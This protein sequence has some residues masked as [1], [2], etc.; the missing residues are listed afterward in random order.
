[1]KILHL[2]DLHFCSKHLKWVNCAMSAAVQI[3]ADEKIDAWIISGD[4]FDATMPVHEPTVDRYAQHLRLLADISPGLVLY[5]TASHD[6]PGSLDF[7]RTIGGRYP[8]ELVSS[9][10]Q[11]VLEYLEDDV[12]IYRPQAW[13]NVEKLPVHIS[14]N[15]RL[16][17]SA[18]PSLNKALPEVMSKGPREW[19]Q[20]YMTSWAQGNAQARNQRIPTLLV[21]HGTVTGCETESKHAMV[22]PDHEFSIATLASCGASATML[23][24]IHKHQHWSSG[25]STGRGPQ[26]IAYAG[27][28]TRL[29]YGQHDPAGCLLWDVEANGASFEFR[30]LPSRRLLEITFDGAPDLAKL[31]QATADVDKDTAVRV[32]WDVDE[33]HAH[34]VDRAGIASVLARA[35]EVKLEGTINPVVSVRAK[36]IGGEMTMRER[37]AAYLATTGDLDSADELHERY[38]MM[39]ADGDVG[40]TVER[41]LETCGG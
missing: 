34:T 30:E 17:V 11:Y 7:V 22:S 26:V 12:S 14:S 35:G 31:A 40:V 28:L 36:G 15:T 27:S 23:G 10:G 8:I 37:L 33:E 21:T 20:E 9:P 29:V 24:H 25:G 2:S 18:M 13:T 32:R 5:G 39:V 38:Q 41:V 6:H 3:A 1:M 19:V 16:L 4:S